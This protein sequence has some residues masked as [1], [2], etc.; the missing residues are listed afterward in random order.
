MTS[1]SPLDD[2]IRPRRPPVAAL[3]SLALPGLGQLYG[4]ELNRGLWL[5]LAFA[6][7]SA[8]G[9]AFAALLAPAPLMLPLLA[10]SAVATLGVWIFAVVDAWRLAA[11]RQLHAPGVWQRSGL[12]VLAFLAGN[13][14]LYF[15]LVGE[16]GGHFVQTFYI[17]TA[18]MTPT[19]LPGDLLF[20]DKRYNCPGCKTRAKIGDVGV[21]VYP[22]DRTLYYIK[23]I[24]G[25]PGDRVAIHGRDVT[26]NGKSLTESARVDGDKAIVSERFGDRAWQVEWPAKASGG[27]A[28]FDVPAGQIFVLGDDRGQAID[29]RKFGAV[30]L[31]D[32]VAKARQIWFSWDGGVRW[33]RL[34]RTVQ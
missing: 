5:F 2:D 24:V 28:E 19:L 17:P 11:R 34:G 12:Y 3:M 4:G 25:L 21:F 27:D 1:I 30:P 10:A 32:L 8:P 6:F 9:I 31:A 22:N 15:G 18:S 29:S 26:I 14:A 13:A 33:G 16:L 20:A 23:R 7:V